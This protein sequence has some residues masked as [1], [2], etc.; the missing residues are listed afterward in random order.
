M[1]ENEYRKKF[2]SRFGDPEGRVVP[3]VLLGRMLSGWIG[4][5]EQSITAVQSHA[6]QSNRETGNPVPCSEVRGALEEIEED[7]LPGVKARKHGWTAK[8]ER[9]LKGAAKLLKSLLKKPACARK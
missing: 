1:E 9:Q 5:G 4:G 7:L 6:P 2:P 3:Q 8:D